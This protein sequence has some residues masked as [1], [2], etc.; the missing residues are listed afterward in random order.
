MLGKICFP[1]LWPSK[2]ERGNLLSEKV[3]NTMCLWA[4]KLFPDDGDDLYSLLTP[5]LAYLQAC[6][7]KQ[8]E[9]LFL[10]SLHDGWV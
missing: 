2:L 4:L 8:K 9:F 3:A 7:R 5:R 10:K 6:A 1:H